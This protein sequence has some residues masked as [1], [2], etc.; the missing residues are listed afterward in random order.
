MSQVPKK[1]SLAYSLTKGRIQVFTA[2]LRFANWKNLVVAGIHLLDLYNQIDMQI[3]PTLKITNDTFWQ[4]IDDQ[5]F[6]ISNSMLF[7]RQDSYFTIPIDCLFCC[8]YCSL[9]LV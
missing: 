3:F 5:L 8:L 2:N 6:N 9:E 4:F 1:N 7:I